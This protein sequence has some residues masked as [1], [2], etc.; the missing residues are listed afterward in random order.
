MLMP[1]LAACVGAGNATGP[2]DA[3][4]L[5][6]FHPNGPANGAIALCGAFAIPSPLT[7]VLAGEPS[8]KPYPIW[9]NQGAAK[10]FVEWP[11]GFSVRFGDEAI[12]YNDTGAQVATA[13]QTVVLTQVVVGSH[14][15]TASDPYLASGIVFGK[16]YPPPT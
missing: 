5:P 10:V 7:G 14:A 6:T 9:L 4:I 2:T 3:A 11:A 15:G 12:L 1:I 16:C 8:S 13:G